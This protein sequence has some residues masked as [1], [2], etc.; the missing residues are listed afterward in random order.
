MDDLI[1]SLKKPSRRSSRARITRSSE[2]GGWGQASGA[3]KSHGQG[4][5]TKAKKEG[6]AVV[7]VQ[8]GPFTR[9]D[10]VPVVAANPVPLDQLEKPGGPGPVFQGD[11]LKT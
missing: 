7:Q 4:I 6:F 1:E 11:F 9:P 2:G 3:G 8:V 10:I 5:E